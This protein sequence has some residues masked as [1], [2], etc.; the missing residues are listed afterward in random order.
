VLDATRPGGICR[1]GHR[2]AL[3]AA[4]LNP[5]SLRLLQAAFLQGMTEKPIE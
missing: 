1:T 3:A 2:P 5:S 4:R